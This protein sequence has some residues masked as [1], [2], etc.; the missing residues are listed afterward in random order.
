[1]NTARLGILMLDTAFPRPV[2]DIGNP[3]SFDFP[4]A[5][6]IV[7][8]ADARTAVLGDE[9]LLLAPFIAAGRE[10]VA[11]GCTGLTTSCGFLGPLQ[12]QLA[13]AVGVPVLASAL[14]MV[15]LVARMLPNG[16]CVGIVTINAATLGPRHFA[17]A[18]IDPATPIA[19]CDPNG[20]FA[21]SIL[22]DQPGIDFAAARHNVV[23][24]A[25][26]LISRVPDVGAIVLECT[27][28]GPYAADIRRMTGRPVWSIID[29]LA[30]F[31]AGLPDCVTIGDPSADGA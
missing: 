3:D 4:V 13:R 24:A 26:D 21:L 19:G 12:N 10:L 5:Y 16:A 23:S 15:P 2:G 9:S 6:R 11:S 30:L 25:T 29:L 17:A 1:M 20:A 8:G 22:N 28:M 18:G 31:H 27:N 7:R 14:M